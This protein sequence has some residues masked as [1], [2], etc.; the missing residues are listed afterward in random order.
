M[1]PLSCVVAAAVLFAIANGAEC[2]E[3]VH[4]PIAGGLKVRINADTSWIVLP[5]GTSKRSILKHDTLIVTTERNGIPSTVTWLLRRDSSRVLKYDGL[6]PLRMAALT[7]YVMIEWEVARTHR[8]D[9][10]GVDG[11]TFP[12]NRD[13][14]PKLATRVAG[15]T[16]WVN[17]NNG[18]TYR[19]VLRSDTLTVVQT[20][21]GKPRDETWLI[22]GDSAFMLNK[23]GKPFFATRKEVVLARRDVAN[24]PPSIP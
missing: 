6:P 8:R 13:I 2:Q 15:D 10:T 16:V 1:T 17:K 12:H 23:A 19:S 20:I 9:D 3:Y 22:K 24:V 5:N 11:P 18:D 7:A 21:D 4:N 14:V